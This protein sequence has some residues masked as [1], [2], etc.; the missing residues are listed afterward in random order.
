MLTGGCYCGQIRY[1]VTVET[2]DSSVC[3]CVDCRRVAGAPVVAW[4]TV[5]AVAVRFVAGSP[6]V[7]ASSAHAQRGFCAACGT[8]LTYVNAHAPESVDIT[9]CSLDDPALVPPQEHIYIRSRIG[10]VRFVDGLPAFEGLR[11]KP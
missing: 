11:P 10:W 3:H 5:P 9:T 2:L 6:K 8:P 7:F 1:E 4:F